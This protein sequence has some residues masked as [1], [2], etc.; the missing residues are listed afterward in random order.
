MST[1]KEIRLKRILGEV[2]K[3]LVVAMDHAAIAGAMGY[4]S[5]PEKIIEK[6]V[7]GKPDSLILT[8]GMLR[9]GVGS[10]HRQVGIILR[11]SGGFTVL[12]TSGDFRDRIISSV[13]DA[14]FYG[15]D[16]VAA[17]IKFGHEMEGTLI[18][19]VSHLADCCARWGVPLLVETLLSVK[20]SGNLEEAE[21]L[22]IAARA[23]AELG[24]DIIKLPLPR[25]GELE[26]IT[27]SCPLPVLILGGEKMADEE[28]MSV[29]ERA[30][31]AG[32]A[33]IC[34]G[35]NVWQREDPASFMFRL[36]EVLDKCGEELP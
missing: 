1:G 36:R 31:S 23:A 14:L 20:G 10:I 35:R 33:G 22:A 26:A 16:G 11:L 2:G 15:A 5:N 9:H 13:Q 12:D 21:A 34:M 30:L 27:E 32:A 8:R 25:E 7:A 6:V 18:E 17:T 4:L 3:S 28:L 19:G 29:I 24:A